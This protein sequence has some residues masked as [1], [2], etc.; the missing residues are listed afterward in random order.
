MSNIFPSL[1]T[2]HLQD[3]SYIGAHPYEK[4][5]T[6]KI[7][8]IAITKDNRLAGVTEF[9]VMIESELNSQAWGKSYELANAIHLGATYWETEE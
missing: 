5:V 6:H 4:D 9:D 8:R 1:P 2:A 3:D 7:L